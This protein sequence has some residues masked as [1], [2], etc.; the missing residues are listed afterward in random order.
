MIFDVNFDIDKFLNKIIIALSN[1]FTPD[2]IILIGSII[3]VTL[4]GYNILSIFLGYSLL[5]PTNLIINQQRKT[6]QEAFK[7]NYQ[8]PFSKPYGCK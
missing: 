6:R 7:K 5:H 3:V 1:F 8:N 4:I 2:R